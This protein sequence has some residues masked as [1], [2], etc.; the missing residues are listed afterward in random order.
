MTIS[1]TAFSLTT[2]NIMGFIAINSITTI[3][4]GLYHPLDVLPI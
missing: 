1:I 4:I 2:H 3:T